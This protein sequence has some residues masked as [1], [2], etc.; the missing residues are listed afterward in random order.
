MKRQVWLLK[1]LDSFF[2]ILQ[3]DLAVSQEEGKSYQLMQ[4][5]GI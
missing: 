2:G 1:V 4:H 5:R 3:H